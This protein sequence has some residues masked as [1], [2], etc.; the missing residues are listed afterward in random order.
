MRR[1]EGSVGVNYLAELRAFDIW[2]V[3]SALSPNARLLWHA[4]MAT[5]N[6]A[7]WKS[8]LS[9]PMSTLEA[10]TG[11]SA[12]A[13]YRAR[14]ELEAAG[15]ISVQH[16]SGRQSATYDLHSIVCQIG[17]QNDAQKGV[18]CHVV[19]QIGTQSDTIYKQNKTNNIPSVS[20]PKAPRRKSAFVPPTVE[21]VRDYCREKGYAY[22]DPA[23]FVAYYA[24]ADWHDRDGKPVKNWKQRVITWHMR[25]AKGARQRAADPPRRRMEDATGRGA[26]LGFYD[27]N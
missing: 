20:P 16:R 4:L 24:E 15:L 18:A 5:A 9:V 6:A 3:T 19:C 14:D 23:F 22:V 1:S 27:D 10:K 13:V 2:V 8:P 12:R 7:R 21:E 25:E 17:T 26:E 11:A